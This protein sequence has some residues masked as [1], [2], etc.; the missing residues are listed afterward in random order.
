MA[1]EEFFSLSGV[2]DYYDVGDLENT[3]GSV[4]YDLTMGRP[5]FLEELILL[6]LKTRSKVLQ[7]ELQIWFSL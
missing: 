3:L 6:V 2:A 7:K 4:R 1:Y 5:A